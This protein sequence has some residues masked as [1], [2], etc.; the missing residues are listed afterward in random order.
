MS[1]GN[2]HLQIPIS[3]LI[4]QASFQEPVTRPEGDR[5][6]IVLG[7]QVPEIDEGLLSVDMETVLPGQSQDLSSPGA[8]SGVLGVVPRT[9]LLTFAESPHSPPRG[10]RV[11][12]VWR[13]RSGEPIGAMQHKTLFF[14]LCSWS[15]AVLTVT[16]LAAV[17]GSNRGALFPPPPP[18]HHDAGS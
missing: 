13:E 12:R 16:L 6:K 10:P 5:D 3:Y 1:P 4:S 15:Q 17:G 7:S 18:H 14:V 8:W 2:V 9:T 11:W